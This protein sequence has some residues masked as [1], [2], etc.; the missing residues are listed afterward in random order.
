MAINVQARPAREQI[1]GISMTKKRIDL[2]GSSFDEQF[3]VVN[4]IP[5]CFKV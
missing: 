3:F 4:I 5:N 2:D 1:F